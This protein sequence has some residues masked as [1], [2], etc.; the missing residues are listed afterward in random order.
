MESEK[1]CISQKLIRRR[2]NLISDIP[3]W[4]DPQRKKVLKIKKNRPGM[5]T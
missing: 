3:G 2:A 5:D 4:F 1:L